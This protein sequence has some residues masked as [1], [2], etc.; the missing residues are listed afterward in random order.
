MLSEI[1]GLEI[2]GVAQDGIEA[3]DR[4]LEL[5]PDVLTLDIRMPLRSGI[6]VLRDI[7]KSAPTT[8]IIILTNYPYPQYRKKCMEEG[9]DFFFDKSTEFEKV[10]EVIEQLLQDRKH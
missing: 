2:I 10:T 9:A 5:K 8:K 4:I 3:R 6:D 1:E 7:K